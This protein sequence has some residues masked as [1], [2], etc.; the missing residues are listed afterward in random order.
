M[1]PW[2]VSFKLSEFAGTAVPTRSRRTNVSANRDWRNFCRKSARPAPWLPSKSWKPSKSRC[3][4]KCGRSRSRFRPLRAAKTRKVCC[5]FDYGDRRF[6]RLPKLGKNMAG[7]A[8]DLENPRDN[9]ALKWPS[10]AVPRSICS[11]AGGIPRWHDSDA[12]NDS[13][14]FR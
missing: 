9:P 11:H 1:L 6:L 12:C 10:A 5:L 13:V 2:K 14:D 7:G 8:C 3:R 4:N